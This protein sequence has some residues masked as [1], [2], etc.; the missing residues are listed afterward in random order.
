MGGSN[1]CVET[2]RYGD[3][4]Y[5]L[6]AKNYAAGPYAAWRA[7][8]YK[9]RYSDARRTGD[10]TRMFASPAQHATFTKG[11]LDAYAA[12]LQADDNRLARLADGEALTAYENKHDL[13]YVG[14]SSGRYPLQNST[15]QAIM[16][17]HLTN[18]VEN[19]A[20]GT[21]LGL[22]RLRHRT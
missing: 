11:E 2:V 9:T 19:S 8:E 12:Y 22:Q 15:Q 13:Y 20:T 18:Y 16:P 4:Y 1:S 7:K 10:P 17:T 21:T 5:L 3:T 14:G 6:D